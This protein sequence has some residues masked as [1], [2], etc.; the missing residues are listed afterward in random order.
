M[1]TPLT[2]RQL[3]LSGN[4]LADRMLVS[5]EEAARLLCVSICTLR[6][7]DIPVVRIGRLRRYDLSAI[8][9]WVL[10]HTE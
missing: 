10:G 5:F 4:A 7:L 3:E 1:S 6:R 8:R 2:R 9:T